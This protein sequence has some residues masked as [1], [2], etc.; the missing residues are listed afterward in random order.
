MPAAPGHCA[1]GFPGTLASS[2]QTAANLAAI[3]L[4]PETTE[5][6]EYTEENYLFSVYSLVF[7]ILPAIKSLASTLVPGT[8]GEGFVARGGPDLAFGFESAVDAAGP[9]ENTRRHE[10]QVR[11]AFSV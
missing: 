1:R 3:S 5:H 11:A 6:T 4:D 7:H 9:L 10:R 2:F 8:P